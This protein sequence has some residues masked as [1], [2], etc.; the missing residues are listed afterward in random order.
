MTYRVATVRIFLHKLSV[1]VLESV[2]GVVHQ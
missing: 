1:Q 2:S